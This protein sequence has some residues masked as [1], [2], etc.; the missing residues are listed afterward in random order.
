MV[1][2]CSHGCPAGQNRRPKNKRSKPER[3]H[4][5]AEHMP[6]ADRFFK[7]DPVAGN[8]RCFG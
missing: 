6:T 8:A 1:E 5:N 7:K 2:A 3:L 4:K